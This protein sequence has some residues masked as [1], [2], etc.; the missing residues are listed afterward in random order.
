MRG[1]GG[2]KILMHHV[3]LT[4]F[5]AGIRHVGNKH[6]MVMDARATITMRN[7]GGIHV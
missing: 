7:L 3:L 6:A 4:H 5:D 2:M 1:I